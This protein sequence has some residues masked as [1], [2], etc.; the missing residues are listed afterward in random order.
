MRERLAAAAAAALAYH[1]WASRRKRTAK[2]RREAELEKRFERCSW[3]SRE[4]LLP[5][6]LPQ[7]AKL[8]FRQS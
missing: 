4:A 6:A 8:S 5:I 7:N 1:W 3:P 2:E